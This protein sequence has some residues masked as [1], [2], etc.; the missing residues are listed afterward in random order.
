MGLSLKDIGKAAAAATIASAAT[1]VLTGASPASAIQTT[2][3]GA[4]DALSNIG[5]NLN[6]AINSGLGLPG[7][8][9][10]PG[11]GGPGDPTAAGFDF[12]NST[13][14]IQPNNTQGEQR[15]D[16]GKSPPFYNELHDYAS[17][18]CIWTMS[19][20][21]RSH[22]N[23]PDDSYRKNILGPII[24][25]S[26]SGSPEDRISL[27]QYSSSANPDGK[28]DFFME[29]VRVTGITGLDKNT[30][31]TNSTGISFT[32][33]EPY[34]VGL[35]F[36]S[37][38]V[39]AFNLNYKNWVE[40]PVLLRLEFIGHKNPNNQNIK[41]IRTKY[42]P[43]KIMNIQMRVTDRGASYDCTA[44]PWN[45]RAYSKQV[46]SIKN[47]ITC[48][49]RTVQEMLQ[50]G[51]KS[52][53]SVI[54][55]ALAS[56]ALA[57]SQGKEPIIPDRVLILF[58]VD[59][60]T[61]NNTVSSDDTSSPT[62]ATTSSRG[63]NNQNDTGVAERLGVELEGINFV[64]NSNVSPI[65]LAD[66]GFIDQR[67]TE[68]TF[69]KDNA[70]WDPDKKVFV[71]GDIT[72]TEKEGQATF[73]QGT[74]IP[75]VIN[76]IILSSDY[77]RQALLP[78]NFDAKGFVNWWKVVPQMYMLDG[79]SNMTQTGK[80]PYLTVYKVIPHKVH[81]SRFIQTDQVAVSSQIKKQAIKKYDYI[82]TSKNLD[83]LDFQINFNAGF[84]TSLAAD[85]GRFNKDIVNRS[86]Q[87]SDATPTKP[88]V[89]N[90]KLTNM[91]VDQNGNK[92]DASSEYASGK[93]GNARV[94]D[95]VQQLVQIRN[96]EIDLGA[97]Q[98]GANGSDPGTIAARQFHKA[99]NSGAE[100]VQVIMKILGDPFYLGDSGL[101]NYTAKPAT[102][103]GVT[104][105]WA[106]NYERGEV[107]IDVNF[108][109]PIDIN[110][111]TGKYDFPSGDVV[112]TFSGLYRVMKVE[113]TFDKGVFTQTLD[114][115]RMPGQTKDSGKE[116]KPDTA[117]SDLVLKF[118]PGD[119]IVD[120]DSL[121]DEGGF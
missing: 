1:K 92:Y 59:T 65:G 94:G 27:S 29:N 99:I 20:L 77:G 15:V 112:P 37:L 120:P 103:D 9:N 28:F 80:Y 121:V 4:T 61:S 114:I 72:I 118:K 75:N 11:I 81:H 83:I 67:K 98:G 2:L 115:L 113:S 50:K 109:N 54:N 62:G 86:Q 25:Q 44:I 16:L 76:Q 32:V 56:Q 8:P 36:Q 70:V 19:G 101:G 111:K 47:D 95:T 102:V 78:E 48:T 21:S 40:M 82:Y 106:I 34:S 89:E 87:A 66:M 23:F 49:G 93:H 119:G 22:I 74:S 30:G 13:T 45:E 14:T 6:K 17:Y 5:Q 107:Y 110:Y 46:S 85:S 90:G 68:A 97:N 10:I 57:A 96:D 52:F 35:F 24:F 91:R 41:S 38:Q 31:N 73:K 39:C 69:G 33:I 79:E 108:K 60:S 88:I 26:G 71:R 64:Q 84:Y 63:T 12:A 55:D 7:V 43:L 51:P 42:F 104:E 18:N 53:Q 58:P 116:G 3:K 100:M 117:G 105:D